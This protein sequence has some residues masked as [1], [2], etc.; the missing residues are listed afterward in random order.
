MDVTMFIIYSNIITNRK[1]INVIQQSDLRME[2]PPDTE[3]ENDFSLKIIMVK[4]R[5]AVGK[6]NMEGSRHKTKPMISI[7]KPMNPRPY[8]EPNFA[9]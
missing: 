9:L 7:K 3:S 6:I 1:K 4:I 8:I 2:N 5:L